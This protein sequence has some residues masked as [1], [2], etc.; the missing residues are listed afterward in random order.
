MGKNFGE[1]T[2]KKL[3][4]FY[5]K[6][7]EKKAVHVNGFYITCITQGWIIADKNLIVSL[8]PIAYRKMV[9]LLLS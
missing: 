9:Q 2:D 8:I 5:S 6:Q 4:D 3:H 1:I 7:A